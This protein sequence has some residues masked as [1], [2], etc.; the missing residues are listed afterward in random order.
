MLPDTVYIQLDD[1]S[2]TP[3]CLSKV[4]VNFPTV[5]IDVMASSSNTICSN[6]FSKYVYSW[7]MQ[8]LLTIYFLKSIKVSINLISLSVE[9]FLVL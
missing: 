9:V 3:I 4:L 7:W 1:Y 8:F 6:I 2:L 5:T